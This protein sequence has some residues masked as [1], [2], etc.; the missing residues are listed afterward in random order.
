MDNAV[1]STKSRGKSKKC[2]SRDGICINSTSNVG[3]SSSSCSNHNNADESGAFMGKE[4][5]YINVGDRN[6]NIATKP[7]TAAMDNDAFS[8]DEIV[9]SLMIMGFPE[10]GIALFSFVRTK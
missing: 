3:G 10:S 9:S 4:C 1:R 2:I 8:R 6:A 5:N 7:S